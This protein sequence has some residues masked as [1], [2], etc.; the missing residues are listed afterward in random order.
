VPCCIIA[1]LLFGL[2]VRS[3]R[4]MRGRDAEPVPVVPKPVVLTSA[5]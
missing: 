4:K 3:W 2:L 1:G 5:S